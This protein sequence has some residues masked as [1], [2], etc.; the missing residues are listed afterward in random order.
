MIDRVS[1]IYV[2]IYI[3]TSLDCKYWQDLITSLY[4]LKQSFKK[5]KTN[6]NP[7]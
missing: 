3:C 2:C 1:M 5:D 4:L 6:L 7:I